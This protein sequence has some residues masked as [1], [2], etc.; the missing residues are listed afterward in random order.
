[1]LGTIALVIMPWNIAL[2]F[3][4]ARLR[5]AVEADC[6]QRVLRRHPDVRAYGAL[7]VDVSE[8]SS[9]AL[10]ARVALIASTSHLAHRVALMTARRPRL[11]VLRAGVAAIVA[12]VCLAAACEA[13]RPTVA[14]AVSTA[15][16][17]DSDAAGGMMPPM[18]G[19]TI[20]GRRL[21]RQQ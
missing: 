15:G 6:D 20:D 19:T 9:S 1:M 18:Q 7:L 12:C 3:A 17:R 10:L 21:T 14:S 5:L 13:P 2:W 8:R 11:R 4:R 16:G